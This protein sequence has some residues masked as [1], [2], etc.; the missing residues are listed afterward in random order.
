[1]LVGTL[2]PVLAFIYVRSVLEQRYWF[3][4]SDI[5]LL[6]VPF[7]LALTFLGFYVL[8]AE[9]K[10]A[11]IREA[12]ADKSLYLQENEGLLPPRFAL[13]FRDFFAISLVIAQGVL[14]YRWYKHTRPRLPENPQ[15]QSIFRWLVFLTATIGLTFALTTIQQIFQFFQPEDAYWITSSTVMVAVVGALVYLFLRPNILYGL[16]GWVAPVVSVEP[17]E[18][19][20]TDSKPVARRTHISAE[21]GAEIRDKV[22]T[23]IAEQKPFLRRGYTIVNMSAELGIPLQQLSAFINQEYGQSFSE[24]INSYRVRYIKEV[25]LKEPDADQ[26][27]LEAIGKKAGFNS[28]GTFIAAVKKQTGQT[29][30]AFLF[31]REVSAT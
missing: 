8:P 9:K 5:F 14:L 26:Y 21:Y 24:F 18:T 25:L 10:V 30:S 20:A 15:N 16:H 6:S 19:T 28:R 3:R 7:L 31:G 29:P 1:V 22:A 13:L 12:L 17:T 11:V 2:Q 27:T 4:R 23:Y